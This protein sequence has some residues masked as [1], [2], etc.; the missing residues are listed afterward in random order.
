MLRRPRNAG[1]LVHRGKEAGPG[2]WPGSLD[3]PTW[4]SLVA[5]LD[6]PG[7][8]TTPGNERKYLGSGIYL[9][10]PCGAT[11]RA[12]TSNREAGKGRHLAA[13]ACREGKHVVRKMEPLDEF[14]QRALLRRLSRP[15]AADLFAV[16]E[17]P[18]DVKG[19][20]SAMREAR[21]TLDMLAE[22]VGSGVMSMQEWRIASKHARQRM[23]AAEVVL[24]R[25]VE[26]NPVAGLVAAEDIEKAWNDLD[27]ARQRAALAFAMTVRVHPA[28]R[29][30]LPGGVYFDTD[31][32][33]IDWK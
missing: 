10:G 12:V 19:A 1:I 28:R 33:Q 23:E 32:V 20:Q 27:L 30:R 18:V 5:L 15:D 7:R 21:R 29:G 14:V 11:L 13:Y 22:E 17:E 24:S 3:E 8:R 4:R 31:S 6:D 2:A 25:A 16:R 26:V 9:C